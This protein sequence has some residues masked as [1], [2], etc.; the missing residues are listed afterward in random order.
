M[1]ESDG[2]CNYIAVRSFVLV[3]QPLR[4]ETANL[5]PARRAGARCVDEMLRDIYDRARPL[6]DGALADYIPELATM[7][8]GSF[9]IAL[10]TLTGWAGSALAGLNRTGAGSFR[11]RSPRVDRH[12]GRSVN[13][14]LS[15]L[16][17]ERSH[18][19]KQYIC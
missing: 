2:N 16:A 12:V 3:G 17:K 8:A 4:Y 5:C 15:P 18:S 19:S 13:P 9:A 11:I 7:P 6:R 14:A 10:A 1:A